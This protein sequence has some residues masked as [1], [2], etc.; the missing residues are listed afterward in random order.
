MQGLV[1]VVL[2]LVFPALGGIY[3]CHDLIGRELQWS[4]LDGDPATYYTGAVDYEQAGKCDYPRDEGRFTALTRR[5]LV[6]QLEYTR[7]AGATPD[8]QD[9]WAKCLEGMTEPTDENMRCFFEVLEL[10]ATTKDRLRNDP[11]G[12]TNDMRK[13]LGYLFKYVGEAGVTVDRSAEWHACLDDAWPN[14]LERKTCFRELM[15]LAAVGGQ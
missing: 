14:T 3:T 9:Q 7:D 8:Q 6:N 1:F 4:T 13:Y 11:Y 5:Y 10:A 15:D 2:L 12:F